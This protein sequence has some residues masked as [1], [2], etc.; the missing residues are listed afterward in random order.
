MIR[1]TRLRHSGL[2]YAGSALFAGGWTRGGRL[3]MR[4][5][6]VRSVRSWCCLVTAGPN[7]IEGRRMICATA[8]RPMADSAA[9]RRLPRSALASPPAAWPSAPARQSAPSASLAANRIAKSSAAQYHE[10]EIEEP[11]TTEC[12][13]ACKT[14]NNMGAVF[15]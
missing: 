12:P 11:K 5:L 2:T 13:S 4:G 15:A 14:A 8:S 7:Q 10:T 6:S 1:A 9:L 3:A